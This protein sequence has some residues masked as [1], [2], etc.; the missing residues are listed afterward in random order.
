MTSRARSRHRISVCT[1]FCAAVTFAGCGGGGT[2]GKPD[3]TLSLS[4]SNVTV[5]GGGSASLSVTVNA[6]NGFN[7]AVTLSLAGLPTGV[8]YSPS[9]LAA[10][11]GS[12]LEITFSAL[13]SSVAASGNVTVTG[14]SGGLSHSSQFEMA[15]KAA[16]AQPP[17]LRTRYV[18]TDSATEYFQLSNSNWM[19]FDPPTKRFFVSDPGGNQIDVL[20]ATSETKVGTIAVPGAYGI[21]ESP[22]HSVL[23]AG[24]SIGDVYAIDPVT[25]QV[26]KRYIAAQIGPNGYKAFEVRVLADGELALLGNGAVPFSALD[27][28]G[29]VGI[30][31]P[32]TNALTVYQFSHIGAFTLTGDRSLIVLGI[33]LS[34]ASFCTLDPGTG[35][36]NCASAPSF[37]YSLAT[38]PDGK[39]IILPDFSTGQVHVFNARTLMQTFTF[40]VSGDLSSAGS[41]I[42]SP[43]SK[44]F[45][46]GNGGG[47]LFAYDLATGTQLG[48]LPMVT[49]EPS[50]GGTA[51]GPIG[52]PNLQA[53]DTSGLLAGP[54]EEGVGFLDLTALKTGPSGSEF[55]NDYIVPATGPVAGGTAAQWKNLSNN[56]VLGAAYFGGNPATSLST[57]QGEFYATTP[58]GN[59]GPADLYAVMEDGGTLIVPEGFS[60]GP[61]IL[62]V[63]PDTSTAEGGGTGII[64]GY[65]FGSTDFGA[66]QIPSDLEVTVNGKSA[67]ISGFA[68]NAYGTLA[69]P[70]DLQAVAYT[71]PAGTAGLKA[72]VTVTTSSGTTTASAALNY[73]PAIQQFT[74]QGAS[75]AQGIYDA[76]RDVYYFT[77]N[78]EIEVFSR[79]KEQ[80]L[81]PIQVPAAPT[82]ATHRLWGIALSP[83]DSLLAVSDNVA[84]AIYLINPDSPGSAQSFVYSQSDPQTAALAQPAGLAVSDSGN[85]YFAATA[86]FAKL[87]TEADQITHYTDP[88]YGG[89]ICYTGFGV[90]TPCYTRG[91]IT[92]D[93]SRV[94][95]NQDGNIFF[96]DTTTD[97]LTWATMDVGCCY[98]NEDLALSSD[99]ST[100]EA[101]SYIYDTNLNAKS[102]Q[103]MNDREAMNIGYVYGVKLSADGGML[104]Q[105][106]TNGIDVFD[107]RVG[108]LLTRV[109][110]PVDL[111]QGFDALV[112]DGKDNILLAITGQS[113][114]GIA[115][116]DLT[117]LPV[118]PTLAYSETA[119]GADDPTPQNR[120]GSNP[121]RPSRRSGSPSA[122]HIPVVGSKHATRGSSMKV[123]RTV[124][125]ARPMPKP[126][127]N[128]QK[129]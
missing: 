119:G 37:A 47:F 76:K 45:Y 51:V 60:Y 29:T 125:S 65:G 114:S 70:F 122:W 92:Q 36:T 21:D 83:N 100:L 24:T 82:G 110:L 72:D 12:G 48:W 18:R 123:N 26:A 43:D 90:D 107:G 91:V 6:M 59:P 19:V 99:Q 95:F 75:L 40:A 86:G 128:A 85:V 101:S 66:T 64:Y 73:L 56:G 16:S 93:N 62:Q 116:V 58:P 13:P 104:F 52:S 22:D 35:N 127:G 71:I 27:G 34:P 17:S 111:S 79:A 1:L 89:Q 42:V 118:P 81:T 32:S 33:I 4:S 74:L 3:F 9:S 61:A 49:V 121:A 129:Y 112:S 80:W 25:M 126:A 115:V 105:P 14:A 30:W 20:D 87:N 108:T 54:M 96:V 10:S 2:G 106:S 68:P 124:G 15:V 28:F 46:I 41:M 39:S 50:S 8:A 44:T 5:T 84:S 78:A 103:A 120:K 69:P 94:F 113:G 97:A 77:N 98:G 109:A 38:T 67:T 117:S 88:P 57:G 31:N 63:T 11:P 23:Y 7:S 55:L 53:F 102:Y